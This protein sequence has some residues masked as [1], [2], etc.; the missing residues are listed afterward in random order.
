[1]GGV[2]KIMKKVENKLKSILKRKVSISEALMVSFLI[3]GGLSYSSES[4]KLLEIEPI[5]KADNII[6]Q[7]NKVVEIQIKKNKTGF[8]AIKDSADGKYKSKLEILG[9][10]TE[11]NKVK[12]DKVSDHILEKKPK[13]LSVETISIEEKNKIEKEIS[14][15]IKKD[16]SKV[17]LEEEV[18]K[19][20]KENSLLEQKLWIGYT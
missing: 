7:R 6:E 3:T 17:K 14:G 16:E 12:A 1:M 2:C 13:Y 15:K 11:I 18:A 10:P 8:I 9:E 4:V 20:C 5:K 19:Y